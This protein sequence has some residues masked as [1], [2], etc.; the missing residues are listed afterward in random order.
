[1]VEREETQPVIE[2]KVGGCESPDLTL[3]AL[4]QRIR[5]QEIISELGVLGLQGAPL[6]TMLNETVRLAAEGLRVQFCKISRYLPEERLLLVEAGVGWE[7]GIVGVAKIGA[8][9]ASPAG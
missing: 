5:Q 9:L 7:P 8:D 6:R 4:E 1:M 3:R 2:S